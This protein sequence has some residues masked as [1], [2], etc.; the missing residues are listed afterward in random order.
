MNR[1]RNPSSN[2]LLKASSIH[3]QSW[4]NKFHCYLQKEKTVAD[5]DKKKKSSHGVKYCGSLLLLRNAN[6]R[7][8]QVCSK[9]LVIHG[10]TVHPPVT[11]AFKF[12]P[13]HYHVSSLNATLYTALFIFKLTI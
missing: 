8:S 3:L 4:G 13:H 1:F 9:S 10:T 5:D 7:N 12:Q 2:Q 6:C 11:F